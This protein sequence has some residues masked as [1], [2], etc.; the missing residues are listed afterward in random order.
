[1]ISKQTLLDFI[2]SLPE[3]TYFYAYEGEITGIIAVNNN[4]EQIGE[5]EA[6][7]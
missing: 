2:H 1:M 7:Y 4:G 3:D 5:L 6:G